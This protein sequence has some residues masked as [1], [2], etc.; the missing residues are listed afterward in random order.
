MPSTI[1]NNSG[2]YEWWT[3]YDENGNEIHTKANNGEERRYEY[4][5]HE[6]GKV[7]TQKEYSAF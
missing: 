2:G 5:Y 3:E 7:K 1:K 6:N 4:T